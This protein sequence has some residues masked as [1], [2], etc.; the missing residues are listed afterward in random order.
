[1]IG[2]P[3]VLA[4]FGAA[5][6][7]PPRASVPRPRTASHLRRSR[8]APPPPADVAPRSEGRETPLA[9]GAVECP[10]PG[11]AASPA[12]PASSSSSSAPCFASIL[13][14]GGR[15]KGL[16]AAFRTTVA[17]P[18]KPLAFSGA[19]TLDPG[20]MALAITAARACPCKNDGQ[21]PRAGGPDALRSPRVARASRRSLRK[22]LLVS[23]ESGGVNSRLDG[24]T[25]RRTSQTNA[26]HC[27]DSS[28]TCGIW[29]SGECATP[30]MRSCA[31]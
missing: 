24:I 23:D 11:P 15:V 25:S 17:H 28:S 5:P 19:A 10:L 18:R 29:S 20:T 6:A 3:S 14:A 4:L 9:A 27:S 16:C 13:L 22:D 2:R 1:M 12:T 7:P 26:R 8:G 31:P 30:P 21:P